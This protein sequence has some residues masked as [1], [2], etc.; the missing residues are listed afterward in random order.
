MSDVDKKNGDI[1]IYTTTLLC[2]FS[3]DFYSGRSI[4]LKSPE[5]DAFAY[6]AP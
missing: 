5:V 3:Q 4:V 1:K 2:L 6:I